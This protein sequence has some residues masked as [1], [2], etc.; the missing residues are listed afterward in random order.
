MRTKGEDGE[1]GS[2]KE[3]GRERANGDEGGDAPG[4]NH[5][6]REGGIPLLLEPRACVVRN[7]RTHT[8]GSISEGVTG[9]AEDDG[10]CG[11]CRSGS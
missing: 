8:G 5:L 10:A 1:R 9:A 7:A 6:R 11:R 3:R 4:I 2:E